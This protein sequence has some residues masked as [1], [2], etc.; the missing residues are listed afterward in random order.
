VKI[1]GW[2]NP[3]LAFEV[4]GQESFGKSWDKSCVDRPDDEQRV[5]CKSNLHA[6]YQSED[7]KSKK[8]DG[9]HESDLTP[10]DAEGLFFTIDL[11]ADRVHLGETPGFMW[12]CFT[13]ESDLRRF[14]KRHDEVPQRGPAK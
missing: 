1:R 5:N 9:N 3:R 13:H 4:V 2:L 11:K 7:V 6:S 14:I 8:R 10:S 12:Q